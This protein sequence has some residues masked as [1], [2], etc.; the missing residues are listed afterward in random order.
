MKK[1]VY[2]L[3]LF[4]VLRIDIKGFSVQSGDVINF[5]LFV[6]ILERSELKSVSRQ[7]SKPSC[8]CKIL[9]VSPN[10]LYWSEVSQIIMLNEN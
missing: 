9:L 3:L 4:E 1:C 5:I 2:D 8:S 7:H 6:G 10:F